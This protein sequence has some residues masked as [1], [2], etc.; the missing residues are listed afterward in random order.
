V[1]LLIDENMPRS[2]ARELQELGFVGID[3][4]DIGLQGRPDDDV[5][6]EATARDA[7][8]I[9]RDRDFAR[10]R[11]WPAGFTAGVIFVNLPPTSGVTAIN[12]RVLSLLSS[13]LPESL[14]GAVTIVES[15]RALSRTVRRRP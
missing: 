3:V 4:R 9:T 13:R 11:L 10:E 14:L 12:A 2:L 1:N 8:I 7:I 15:R 6:A 5:L